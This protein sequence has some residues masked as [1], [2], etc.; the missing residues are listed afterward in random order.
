MLSDSISDTFAPMRERAAELHTHPHR[1]RE[2][3]EDGAQRAREIARETMGVVRE[4]M[5]LDWRSAAG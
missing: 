3:L 4:R 5:G 2:I 1:V